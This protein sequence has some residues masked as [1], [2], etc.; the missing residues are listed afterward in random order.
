MV[1]SCYCCLRT[2]DSGHVKVVIVIVIGLLPAL[3]LQC[4]CCLHRL[5]LLLLDKHDSCRLPLLLL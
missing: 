1:N 3:L 2:L 4:T 5:P